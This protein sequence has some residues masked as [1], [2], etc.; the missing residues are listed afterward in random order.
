MRGVSIANSRVGGAACKD[1]LDV[2]ADGELDAIHANLTLAKIGD[3]HQGNAAQNDACSQ[4][5]G[6]GLIGSINLHPINGVQYALHG[7]G[8][9][10]ATASLCTVALTP[11]LPRARETPLGQTSIPS[12]SNAVPTR[13]NALALAL[14]M[15]PLEPSQVVR[16]G[17]EIAARSATSCCESPARLR[18]AR[19]IPPVIRTSVMLGFFARR[20]RAS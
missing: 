2:I 19:S 10:H 1:P 13:S 17:R 9:C 14:G 16:L 4:E 6:R 3:P 15:L 11:G 18:A 8:G 7:C 5:R 12:A 20:E